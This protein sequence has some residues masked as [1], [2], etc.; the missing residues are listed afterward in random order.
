MTTD[1]EK[2]NEQWGSLLHHGSVRT[3]FHEFGHIMDHICTKTNYSRLANT[4]R[5]FSELP[6]QMLEN[7]VWD[8]AILKRLSH[9]H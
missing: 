3:F 5:D 1:F 9:H 7:W 8:K 4:E 6:S 2:N